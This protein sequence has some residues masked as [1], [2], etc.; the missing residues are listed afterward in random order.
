MVETNININSVLYVVAITLPLPLDQRRY[1]RD[2]L[3]PAGPGGC[4]ETPDAANSLS[5]VKLHTV[6]Q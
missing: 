3:S 2:P 1:C 4:R 5:K 6:I